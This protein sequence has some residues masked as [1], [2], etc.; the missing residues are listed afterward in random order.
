M[1]QKYY[2]ESNSFTSDRES[3]Q[4]L[5]GGGGSLND[6]DKSASSH[7][8]SETDGMRAGVE[9]KRPVIKVSAVANNPIC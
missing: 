6:Q 3:S 4:G 1:L 5:D 2:D 8:S 7:C 9:S